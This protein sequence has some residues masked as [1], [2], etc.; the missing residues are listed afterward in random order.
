MGGAN[1]SI[2]MGSAEATTTGYGSSPTPAASSALAVFNPSSD[3]AGK[4]YGGVLL[5]LVAGAVTLFML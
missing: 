4:S 3:A 5:G 1:S 2:E